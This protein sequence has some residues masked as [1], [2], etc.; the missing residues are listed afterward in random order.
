[1]LSVYANSVISHPLLFPVKPLNANISKADVSINE[2][3][4]SMVS[5]DLNRGL[6]DIHYR[7][8]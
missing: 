2:M 7:M 5:R 4:C 6:K 3:L 8:T 1:M